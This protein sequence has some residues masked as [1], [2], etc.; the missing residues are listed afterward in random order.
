MNQNLFNDGKISL[1]NEKSIS[2]PKINHLQKRT[3]FTNSNQNINNENLKNNRFLNFETSNFNNENDSE[4]FDNLNNENNSPFQQINQ[5]FDLLNQEEQKTNLFKSNDNMTFKNGSQDYQNQIN[6][7]NI[8]NLRRELE[9]KNIEL[10][11]MSDLFDQLKDEYSKL[12]AKYNSLN[13]YASDLKK[14]IDMF[15]F[16]KNQSQKEKDDI[17]IKVIQEKDNIISVLENQVNYYKDACNSINKTFLSTQVNQNNFPNEF[18]NLNNQYIQENKKLKNQLK[19][20]STIDFNLFETQI[21][22][23]IDNFNNI[24]NNYN[25]RLNDSLSQIPEFFNKNQ[26]EEAAKYLVK[27]INE[28]MNENQKLLSDNFKLNIQVNEL[29]AQLKANKKEKKDSEKKND[30]LENK[31]EELESLIQTLSKNQI[32]QNSQMGTTEIKLRECLTN[33]MNELKEKDKTILELKTQL[34]ESIN[35]HSLNFDERQIVNSMSR[36]LYEKDT[37]IQS[38]KNQLDNGIKRV[39]EIKK[40]KEEFLSKIK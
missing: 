34:M 35:K 12:N 21:N 38:L 2:P 10:K 23:Q 16:E 8:D 40:N 22:I 25:K 36:K 29:Q 15:N 32:N 37:L 14:Q 19:Q 28:F 7:I 20:Y 4:N 33:T 39:D 5:N 30:E 9:E 6:S 17:T 13:I 31:I 26:K 1:V 3:L 11:K 18:D 27:Q 24:L